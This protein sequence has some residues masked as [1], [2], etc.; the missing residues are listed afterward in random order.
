MNVSQVKF[1]EKGLIPAIVQ[2]AVNKEVLTLAY[3][4]EES[5]QKSLETKETWFWSRSRAKLWHKGETSGNT[6]KIIDIKYDCDQDA[7]VVL[8]V[9]AGPAC[10]TGSYS[11]FSGSLLADGEGE[12]VGNQKSAVSNSDRFAVINELESVIAKREA[13]M[14]EGAYTTYLF[15]KGVDKILKKVGEEATEVVIA[16]KNRDPEE[17]KWEVADLIYHV[18]VLLREQ[19]LPLD[20][21][22]N[23]LVERHSQKSK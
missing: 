11:C 18:L 7:L 17:L 3:M 1:D 2:D 21:V 16:A 9:P 10:H 22:L 19:K 8:V 4:N 12:L 23:V 20:E 13:E 5:L 15:D 6:Q 14:P